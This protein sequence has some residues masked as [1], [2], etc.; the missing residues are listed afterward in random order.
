MS[1]QDTAMGSK[2][3]SLNA[4]AGDGSCMRPKPLRRLH[5]LAISAI[6]L[7]IL[8]FS[9]AALRY[10]HLAA[11][12]AEFQQRLIET[13]SAMAEIASLLTDQQKKKLAADLAD[14][15][16]AL[17]MGYAQEEAWWLLAFSSMG[18]FIVCSLL[19]LF[20][21]QYSA[22]TITLTFSLL[23]LSVVF[24]L[25]LLARFEWVLHGLFRAKSSFGLAEQW[26]SLLSTDKVVWF[27]VALL[28]RMGFLFI[29]TYGII[30]GM[31]ASSVRLE[32]R[33]LN[34]RSEQIAEEL[35]KGD[36][37]SGSG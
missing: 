34:P 36:T 18:A 32:K 3:R 9:Q 26:A 6:A 29:A 12:C 4:G 20:G 35:G 24:D 28:S 30:A 7:S 22:K 8:D 2:A 37:S 11:V 25:I 23:L 16:S 13:K 5:V 27:P 31:R 14:F 1:G 17:A 15:P 33:T 21:G 19:L 10:R